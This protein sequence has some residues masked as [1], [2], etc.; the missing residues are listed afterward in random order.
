MKKVIAV[1]AAVI[2]IS[3][4]A[5]CRLNYEEPD[6]V[7]ERLDGIA[8]AIGNSQITPDEALLGGRNNACD[9]YTGEYRAICDLQTGRDV[10]FGGG[11]IEKRCVRINGHVSS[12]S[13]K[14]I[15]RIRMNAVVTEVETDSKGNFETVL[16]MTGGGNYIM[17]DYKNFSGSVELISEYCTETQEI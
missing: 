4:F 16:S 5:S 12:L 13:G 11:S 3:A 1:F 17:V 9:A 8:G 2:L 15:V 10:I 7:L 14:A 6:S